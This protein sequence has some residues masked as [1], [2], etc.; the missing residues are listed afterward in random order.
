MA[1]PADSTTPGQDGPERTDK[2]NDMP[3][4]MIFDELVSF[5]GQAPELPSSDEFRD[6][7]IEDTKTAAIES[8]IDSI[9]DLMAA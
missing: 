3:E 8:L 9:D 1:T 6:L 5:L 2:G 4:D 7:L